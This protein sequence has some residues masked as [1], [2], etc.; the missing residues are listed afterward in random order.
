MGQGRRHPAA[1]CCS[2]GASPLHRVSQNARLLVGWIVPSAA[3]VLRGQQEAARSRRA[4]G[5]G[6]PGPDAHRSGTQLSEQ[7]QQPPRLAR[8]C[9]RLAADVPTA[10]WTLLSFSRASL[11]DPAQ[12]AASCATALVATVPLAQ[13]QSRLQTQAALEPEP[14]TCCSSTALAGKPGPAHPVGVNH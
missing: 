1:S 10:P 11:E 13:A 12:V 4:R 8:S 3:L 6:C 2:M 9:A 7:A 5:P 14:G